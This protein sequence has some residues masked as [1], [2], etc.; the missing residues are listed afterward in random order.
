[1]TK[2]ENLNMI[3]G[4][5]LAQLS[6]ASLQTKV[7]PQPR[8]TLTLWGRQYEAALPEP[9]QANLES[10]ALQKGTYSQI[11]F[12][13]PGPL[14]PQ[15]GLVASVVLHWR[16][17]AKTNFSKFALQPSAINLNRDI[18]TNGADTKALQL[19]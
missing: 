9:Q 16:D 19:R 6:E 10:I 1:M 12:A 4:A 18:D 15:G 17:G 7:Q 14:Q 8:A 13:P 2:S 3:S 5:S 11:H